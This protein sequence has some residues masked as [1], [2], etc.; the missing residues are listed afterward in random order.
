[1]KNK[2]SVVLFISFTASNILYTI[3]T[4]QKNVLFWINS[5]SKRQKNAKKITPTVIAL[6]MQL[7]FKYLSKMQFGYIHVCFKGESKNKKIILKTIKK[8]SRIKILSIKNKISN[9]HN[10]CQIK[11][12]K[13]L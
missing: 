10:G 4:L 7:L 3:T 8:L 11:K 12:R 1:M 6:I 2:Q 5:G 13:R 9:S